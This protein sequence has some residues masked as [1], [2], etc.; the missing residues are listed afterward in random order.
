MLPWPRGSGP[1]WTFDP[2]LVNSGR[3][4]QINAY[5]SLTSVVEGGLHKLIKFFDLTENR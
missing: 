2:I 3:S 4:D 1:I 5:H